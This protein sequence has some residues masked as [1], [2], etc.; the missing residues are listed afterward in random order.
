MKRPARFGSGQAL[1]VIL[2]VLAVSGTIVLSL[3]ARTVTDIAITTKEKESS[4]A[5]SAAEAGIEEALV[6]GALE[7]T[8]PGGESYEVS[9]GE[10]GGTSQELVWPQ[11]VR[12][13]ETIP[14]W[15]VSHNDQGT[16]VCDEANPCFTGSTLKVCW[17]QEGTSPSDAQTPAIEVAIIYFA[18]VGD[19]STAR[20]ARAALDPNSSRR[21]T[22]KFDAP[23]SGTCLVSDQTFAFGKTIDLGSVGIPSSVYNNQNGLQTVRVRSIYNSDVA[24]P[25]AVSGVSNFPA[26]GRKITSSG[27]ADEATREI[28]VFQIFADLPPV[29]DFGVFTPSNLGK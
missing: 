11:L 24:Q 9:I 6:G 16:L 18:T 14:I 22:N 19:A 2:L 20:I 29:F 7:G 3:A 8:L 27:V 21:G 10:V 28:E 13:G 17:G 1:L 23:D 15:L 4:R 26:Q 25:L 5:F 12:A